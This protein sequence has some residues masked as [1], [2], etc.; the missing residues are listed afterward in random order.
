MEL[1][2]LDGFEGGRA[3]GQIARNYFNSQLAMPDTRYVLAAIQGVTAVVNIGQAIVGAATAAQKEKKQL[4]ESSKVELSVRNLT[5]FPITIPEAYYLKR[6]ESINAVVMPKEETRFV[7]YSGGLG[8]DSRPQLRFK[9]YRSDEPSSRDLYFGLVFMDKTFDSSRIR[10]LGISTGFYFDSRGTPQ[11][12]NNPYFEKDKD[13]YNVTELDSGSNYSSTVIRL[14]KNFYAV[15][16]SATYNIDA[17][18]NITFVSDEGC[19]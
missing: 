19:S 13:R 9:A 12:V 2:F 4:K 3:A 10:T 6:S 17:R 1:V 14:E 11:W 7:L 18:L 8:I 15:A 16:V 5:M